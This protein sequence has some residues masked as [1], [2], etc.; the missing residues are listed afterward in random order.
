M[1]NSNADDL[2]TFDDLPIEEIYK[3]LLKDYKAAKVEIGKLKSEIDELKYKLKNKKTEVKV[4]SLKG[5][6]KNERKECLLEL[7]REN[8]TVDNLDQKLQKANRKAIEWSKKY[9]RLTS[10]YSILKRK[11]NELVERKDAADE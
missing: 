2:M 7:Y 9:R 1:K 3:Y 5:I 10:E 8:G 4:V 6:P 11:Y